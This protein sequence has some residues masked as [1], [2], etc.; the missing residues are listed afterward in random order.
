MLDI[1]FSIPDEEKTIA[2]GVSGGGDSMALAHMLCMWAVEHKRFAHLLTVNHNLRPESAAE[3]EQ[4]GA[5]V[6]DFPA[7]SHHIL[8]W[9]HSS[10]PETALMERA[11]TARYDLMAA[12][13]K[14]HDIKTLVVAHHA[15]DQLETFLFRLA[16][17]SGLDGL[18]GMDEA[19][20]Y[21]NMVLYRPLLHV[22]HDDLIA[23]C[24]YHNLSWIEDPSNQNNDFARPRLRKALEAEGLNAK[25][26]VKT[27]DRLK[28]GK[29]ALDEMAESAFACVCEDDSGQSLDWC[30]LSS[31]PLDIRIRVVQKALMRHG[32]SE[33]S[34]PPKLERVEDIIDTIRPCKSATLY[35]CVLSLSKDGNRLEITPS[36]A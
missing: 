34:Y 5:W 10:R 6:A 14:A 29:Q 7:S 16:K 19:T 25:R 21:N 20:Q 13:C 24:K 2:I 30:H 35:G 31:Y 22:T 18:S 15:D 32:K 11:R 17:G 33:S 4:V 23:Y 27:L 8:K 3:A 12:Y 9:D 28:R 1:N 36:K 26:L